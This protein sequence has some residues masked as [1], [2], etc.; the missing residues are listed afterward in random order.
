MVAIEQGQLAE[1]G[2]RAQPGDF[3]AAP[4]DIGLAVH[5]QEELASDGALFDQHLL[6]R[7]VHFFE[8]T[9]DLLQLAVGAAREEPDGLE[10]KIVEMEL[11]D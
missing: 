1:V 7:D 3:P 4:G 9:P 6:G 11:Y 10:I 5:D 2:A 8:Q